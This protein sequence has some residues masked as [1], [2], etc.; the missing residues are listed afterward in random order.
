MPNPCAC[1][2]RIGRLLGQITRHTYFH[3]PNFMETKAA[4]RIVNYCKDGQFYV[5][6]KV[7]WIG[8]LFATGKVAKLSTP[9]I[10]C[11]FSC[12]AFFC[13]LFFVRA[14]ELQRN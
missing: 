11:A 14:Y 6:H 7:D 8:A 1:E 3:Q 9:L 5:G 12:S 4:L 2:R 13:P 10:C